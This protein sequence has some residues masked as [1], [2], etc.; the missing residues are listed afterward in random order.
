M[1]RFLD[2]LCRQR[3]YGIHGGIMKFMLACGEVIAWVVIALILSTAFANAQ[4][5]DPM[6]DYNYCGPP[7]RDASGQIIRR[8][9]VLRR[10]QFL[11]PC[12][13]TGSRTGACPG[14]FKDHVRPL[15]CGGCDSVSNLQWLDAESKKRK[16][17]YER[18][19]YPAGIP[20][21]ASC[22]FKIAPQ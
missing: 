13:S 5:L 6:K 4:T 15:A 12:R 22:I 21:T 14:Y 11:Y 18:S 3:N 9:D 17:S 10:F 7:K 1:E 8:A 19:L 16:D 20:D 2:R